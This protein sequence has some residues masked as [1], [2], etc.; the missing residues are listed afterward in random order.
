MQNIMS[1]IYNLSKYGPFAVM[2]MEGFFGDYL[3]QTASIELL[4][5]VICCYGIYYIQTDS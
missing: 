4:L 3:L 5:E 2:H 1:R